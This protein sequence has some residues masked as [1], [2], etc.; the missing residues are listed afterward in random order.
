MDRQNTP[1]S[2]SGGVTAANESGVNHLECC[3]RGY[4]TR[5]GRTGS[6][7]VNAQRDGVLAIDQLHVGGGITD[8]EYVTIRSEQLQ[9]DVSC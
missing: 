6:D 7:V 9:C 2:D 5:R 3:S 4:V 8:I 1:E